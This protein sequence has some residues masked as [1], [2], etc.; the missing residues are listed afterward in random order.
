M[1]WIPL[2]AINVVSD[3]IRIFIDNYVSDF[4]FKG[5]NSVSQK[6]FYGYTDLF[7]APIIALCFSADFSTATIS[8]IILLFLSGFLGSIGGIPYYR[9]L[10]IEDSTSIGIFIQFA[11]VLYLILGW[12]FL[13]ES[14]SFMQLISFVLILSAPLVIVFAARKKSRHLKVQAVL[15]ALLYVVF[16]VLSTFI[17]VKEGSNGIN[18][19]GAAT[20]VLIGKGV[21][22]LAIVYTHP[23]WRKRFY[24]VVSKSK[25]KALRPMFVNAIIGIIASLYYKFAL[26]SAP[27]V[28]LASAI[29]DTSEPIL[30][31]F[32]GLLLTLIWPKFGREKLNKKT[33]MAHLIATILVVA[34]VVIM[35]I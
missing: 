22:N 8:T 7:F 35:Q 21:G 14:F 34:G 4:Y 5:K 29:S 24:H 32:M 6:L 3:S 20:L 10:E 13:G 25:Y 1:N 33:V 16:Y 9:A 2:I 18:I 27:S 31:F 30:I 26:A 12:F 11:P 23:K 15:Y 28:A 19:A 17:F